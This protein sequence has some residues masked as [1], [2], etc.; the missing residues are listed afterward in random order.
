MLKQRKGTRKYTVNLP[1]GLNIPG[2]GDLK[3]HQK[4]MAF[5]A[6]QAVSYVVARQNEGIVKLVLS[7]LDKNHGGVKAY[8]IPTRL[9]HVEIYQTEQDLARSSGPLTQEDRAFILDHAQA[10]ELV[11]ENNADMQDPHVI[12]NYLDHVRETKNRKSY[13]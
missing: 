5:S 11:C 2:Y 12:M 6:R 3:L 9:P 7:E 1:A 8:A 13:N 4:T 10:Y